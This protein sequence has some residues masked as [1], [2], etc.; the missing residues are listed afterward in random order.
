MIT[1]SVARRLHGFTLIELLVTVAILAVL[2]TGAMTLT[3][4]AA[5]RSREQELRLA[6]RQIRE[7][8]DAYKVAADAKRIRT[9]ADDAGYPPDLDALTRGVP[10]ASRPDGRLVYF[11]RRLPRDP[12]ADAALPAAQ[13][14]GLRSY[15]SEPDAPQPGRDVFD[16]YS[17]SPQVGLNG[18]PYREW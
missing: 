9:A 11:L 5:K 13:T 12:M 6:L 18:R 15:E 4:L 2:A 3:D 17:L 14:W 1:A 7:A 8:I 10:D 16:V